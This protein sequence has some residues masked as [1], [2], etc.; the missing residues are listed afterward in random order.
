MTK[1]QGLTVLI[2]KYA[3]LAGKLD[4]LDKETRV[5]RASMAH[6]D[7]SIQLIRHGY[8]VRSIRPKRPY[9][10]NPYVKRGSY[11]RI[12]MNILR[13]A[14][15][16]LPTREICCIAL[17]KQGAVNP[18][19]KIVKRM[20]RAMETCLM[21]KVKEGKLIVDRNHYP[22]QFFYNQLDSIPQT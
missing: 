6:L 19:E 8:D 1:S 22:K 9:Y 14:A 15:E 11:A 16:P 4:A 2:N 18:D 21:K 10:Y 20:V 17:H 13:D 5:V 12:A 7:A 3:E